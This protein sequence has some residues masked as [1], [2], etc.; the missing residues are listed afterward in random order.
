MLARLSHSPNSGLDW[1]PFQIWIKSNNLHHCANKS[2]PKTSHLQSCIDVISN[3]CLNNQTCLYW[4]FLRFWCS[5]QHFLRFL[6]WTHCT[7]FSKDRKFSSNFL[8]WKCFVA[9]HSIPPRPFCYTGQ[10]GFDSKL[11]SGLADSGFS[12][13]LVKSLV[14]ISYVLAL[15]GFSS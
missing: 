1:N 13:K 12:K 5:L 14:R 4:H 3:N 11:D 2:I 7:S 15:V 10:V 8:F 9:P 6:P